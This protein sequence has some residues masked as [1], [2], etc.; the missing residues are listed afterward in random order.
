[1]FSSSNKSV[2]NMY[3]KWPVQLFSNFN[4]C[5]EGLC[6][7][8]GQT[9]EYILVIERTLHSTTSVFQRCAHATSPCSVFS[10]DR[11][12]QVGSNYLTVWQS[13]RGEVA[14][15][16]LWKTQEGAVR[17]ITNIYSL[18]QTQRIG[19]ICASYN[20]LFIYADL[21]LKWSATLR[22]WK[23]KQSQIS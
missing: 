8:I 20:E 15:A 14:W 18:G 2:H 10:I 21:G 16:H 23:P 5:P 17:S 9:K 7:G 3:T 12:H 4:S 22:S 13:R 1:M 19:Y 11:V 6:E